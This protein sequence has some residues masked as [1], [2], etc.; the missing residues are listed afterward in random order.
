MS[1]ILEKG[2]NVKWSHIA[3]LGFAKKII[4]LLS[5]KTFI[6]NG[7]VL[8]E[9]FCHLSW[10]FSLITENQLFIQTNRYIV[11][12]RKPL[13]RKKMVRFIK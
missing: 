3:G 13:F 4:H 5:H 10:P 9:T 1:D 11:N 2:E 6:T 8:S 12:I 7:I